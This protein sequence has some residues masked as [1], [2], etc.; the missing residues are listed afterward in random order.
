VQIFSWKILFCILGKESGVLTY[1][2]LPSERVFYETPLKFI[3]YVLYSWAAWRN[4][5]SLI[6]E[7]GKT[8]A[9]VG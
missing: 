4:G 2:L 7:R 3:E 1:H 8:I 5:D 6:L 9:P